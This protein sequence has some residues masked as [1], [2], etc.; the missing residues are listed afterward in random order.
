M[1]QLFNV[2]F[3][4]ET[5]L[6]VQITVAAANW[7]NFRVGSKPHQPG[8]GL[9]ALMPDCNK[10]WEEFNKTQMTKTPALSKIKRELDLINHEILIYI[11]HW[12]S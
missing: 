5:F 11:D 12:I 3:Y 2:F 8:L 1:R 9:E 4:Q 7:V 6:D 10:I